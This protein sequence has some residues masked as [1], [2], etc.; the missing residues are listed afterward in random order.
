MITLLSP[1]KTIDMD[2]AIPDV[3]SSLPLY[4]EQ[5]E[6]LMNN[7]KDVEIK[8]LQNI[9]NISIS[10]AQLNKLRN[11][12]WT[13]NHNSD[14]SRAAI[15]AYKGDVYQ[16][17]QAETSTQESLRFAQD[18]LFIISGLY[19]ILRPLDLI[20]PYRLEMGIPFSNPK[21]KTLYH[22]WKH[23]VNEFLI[24]AANKSNSSVLMNL[25]SQEYFKVVDSKQ[26]GL[27]V[28]TPEFKEFR[29]DKLQMISFFAKKARGL[30]ARYIIDNQITN[31][32][33]I[34]HFEREGYKFL[35]NESTDDKWVFAR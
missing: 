3:H 22:F 17:L 9:M 5:A 4:I 26:I 21:G 29:K 6:I 34:K 7:L 18:R 30:M 33:D 19:G 8:E 20:M 31:S 23:S 14:N 12:K 13:A 27:S 11:E 25:A 15:F 1:A 16:G 24:Q 10:L 2:A 35:I 32:E 28:I